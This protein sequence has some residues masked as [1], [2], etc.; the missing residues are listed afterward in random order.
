MISV[1][2]QYSMKLSLRN[3]FSD[4]SVADSYHSLHTTGFVIRSFETFSDKLERYKRNVNKHIKRLNGICDQLALY[5]DPSSIPKHGGGNSEVAKVP[6]RTFGN[7]VFIV[8]GRDEEAK[9]KVARFVEK[10]GITATILH[11]QANK[12]QTIIEKFEVHAATAGFAIVLLTPDDVAAPKGTNKIKPRARQNVILEL[13][14]FMG[15]LGRKRVCVLHKEKVELPSDIH[16]IV[17]VPMDSSDGWQLRL[18]QEMK[19]AELPIDM[20]KLV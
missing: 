20:N 2:G 8:H 4:T 9:E 16:G 17:Y 13:G 18:A 14:Y 1:T 19:Q 15:R 6:T 5:E 10:L 11:E 12:G 3:F 7:E